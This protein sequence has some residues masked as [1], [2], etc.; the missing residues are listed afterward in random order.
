MTE[1]KDK[2]VNS[3]QVDLRDHHLE[4]HLS[5]SSH[6]KTEHDEKREHRNKIELNETGHNKPKHHKEKIDES[7]EKSFKDTHAFEFDDLA[8]SAVKEN[9]NEDDSSSKKG[10]SDIML[11]VAIGIIVVFIL[12]I[13]GL[14][15][16]YKSESKIEKYTYNGFEF[17]KLGDIWYVKVQPFGG[18]NLFNVP[19]HFSPRDVKDISVIGDLDKNFNSR[20]IYIT[21]DPSEDKDNKDMKF[22]ALASAE[23]SLSMAQGLGTVPLSA[24][25]KNLTAAC[26]EKPIKDCSSQES[27][28]YL[29]EAETP[30]VTFNGR[31]VL[32]E[33]KDYELVKATDRLLLWWYGV[34][35][36][37]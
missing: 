19:L 34:M 22:I 29:R 25:A 8:S 12:A 2:S 31:C 30:K 37:R 3:S 9:D 1:E 15:Y 16:L 5:H 35:T 28:I 4:R 7:D 24:C 10:K 11:Y 20:E 14:K 26:N 13:F 36:E 17:K 6:S 18:T 27:V 21:F 32:I 33:G 23:L